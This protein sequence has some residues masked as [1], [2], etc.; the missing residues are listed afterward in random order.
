[1]NTATLVPENPNDAHISVIFMENDLEAKGDF[2]PAMSG[3]A[4]FTPGYIDSLL[5]RLNIVY[6]VQREAIN[7]A[8]MR[9]TKERKIIKD[10]VIASGDPPANEV[11]EYIQ[12]NPL[13]GKSAEPD[14]RGKVDYREQS[15]FII[16][17]KD[18]ALAKQKSRKPGKDGMNVHGGSIPHGVVRPEGVSG[19]DN[20]R[21]EGRFMLSNINGQLIETKGM[22]SV[23]NFLVIK[24]PV[25]YKTGNIVFPG[26]VVIEGPVSD[27]FKIYSG[28]SVSIKQTFDVT[29]AITK[30]DL[31]VAG[32][33]IGRGRA[34]VKVGGVLKTKFI[35]N[36]RVACRK[37][38]TVDTDIINSN[39]FTLENVEMGDKGAILGGEIY[40]VKGVRTGNIG[41]KSGK[42]THIHCGIDFTVQQ[43]KEKNNNILRIVA[44]KLGRLKT[45]MEDPAAD[46]PKK[47][48][49]EELRRRLEA[50]QQ[51]ASA[52]VTELMGHLNTYDN[53][54]VEV[55]GEI[56]AGTLI[57]IC[58]IALFV[59]EPLKKVR[60]KLDKENGKLITENL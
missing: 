36:C 55:S 26:D 60:V 8:A 13:L 11:L 58:Q 56:A 33:I 1:M 32:G 37:T 46:E 40:A 16:V 38:V 24:G 22:V 23:Q 10:V 6:G 57:E 7:E 17:K 2:V 48:K 18:Q 14:A 28:G 35:E 59:T 49:M 50:E 29:D 52:V 41:K 5:Q 20:T 54:T 42:S 44:A 21:M 3:G 15:P 30:T 53:A 4:P 31:S 9:C 12:L 27:G 39:V 43:E 19:G 47:A 34:L 45:M 51:K 25:G